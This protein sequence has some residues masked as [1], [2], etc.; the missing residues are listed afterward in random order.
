MMRLIQTFVLVLTVVAGASATANATE[1]GSGR[2]FG[3]GFELGDPTGFT[4]KAFIGRGNAIDFG[5]AFGGYGY[6]RCRNA[7]GDR[8][9]CDDSYGHDFSLIGDYLWQDNLVHQEVKLDWHIGAGARVIFWN[10]FNHGYVD[11]IARMP[12]GLD[13]YFRRPDFLEVF[14]EIAPGIILTHP[15]FDLDADIG[16]RFFF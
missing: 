13:L 3:L 6:G 11:L 2:N 15:D 16:V 14:F 4:G 10:A 9:Y 7:N 1:V 5:V 12:L 8:V